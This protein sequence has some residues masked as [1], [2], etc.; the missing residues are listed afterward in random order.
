MTGQLL[1]MTVSVE[2]SSTYAHRLTV[3]DADIDELGHA[4]NIAY[5]R[6]LQD[7]AVAHSSAVGL[8][9]EA[10]ARL[11]GVFVVRRQEVDYLRSALRGD[12]VEV[13]TR[14]SS[15]MAA[16]CERVSEIVRKADEEVLLRALTTWGYV[17]ASLGRPSRIPDEVLTAFGFPPRR[18]RAL[19]A[20][21]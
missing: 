5:I 15:F 2:S 19:A 3:G 18:R 10:Y 6:W 21:P 17:D 12:A 20:N 9:W 13:R 14:I 7:S 1:A 4:S 8:G 11:G 16:K